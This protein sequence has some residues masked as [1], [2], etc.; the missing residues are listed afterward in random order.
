VH[1]EPVTIAAE[2]PAVPDVRAL[3]ERHLAFARAVTRAEDVHA[4]GV[5]GLQAPE[6]TF[7]TARVGGTLLGVAALKR[8][9][10]GQAEVKSMHTAQEARHRGIARLLLAEV[11]ER[12]RGAGV[13]TLLLET[14]SQPAFAA[15][16]ALYASAGF[17]P[18]G[19]FADY[20]DKPA[21]AF[22]ALDLEPRR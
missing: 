21:S 11:V 19:P 7:L 10:D 12:A 22:M 1:H 9:G 2:D 4:L 18:C 8:L 17:R 13:R 5:S 6:V 20:P 16:R 14:G 3:L 15:A